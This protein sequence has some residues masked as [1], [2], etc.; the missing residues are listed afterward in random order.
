MGCLPM[1]VH[2]EI[3]HQAIWWLCEHHRVHVHKP[4]A[5]LGYMVE[6]ITPRLQAWTACYCTKQHKIKSST[7]DNVAVKRH[8]KPE[9]YAATASKTR[10]AV[11]QKTFFIS[12]KTI[13]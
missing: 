13:L 2:S 1:G 5:H 10:R 7:R 6:L 12:K 11:L 3:P 4:V 8:G 9:V